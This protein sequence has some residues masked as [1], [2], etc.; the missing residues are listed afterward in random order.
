MS[1]HWSWRSQRNTGRRKKDQQKP[2][3]Q[4]LK[5]NKCYAKA[6]RRMRCDKENNKKSKREGSTEKNK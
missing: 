2:N 6:K 1:K 5:K 3:K 4:S